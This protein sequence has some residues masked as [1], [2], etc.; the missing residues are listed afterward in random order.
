MNKLLICLIGITLIICKGKPKMQTVED[1]FFK[2]DIPWVTNIENQFEP[3][4]IPIV[5]KTN[6]EDILKFYPDGPNARKSFIRIQTKVD[7]FKTCKYD[8]KILFQQLTSEPINGEGFAGYSGKEYIYFWVYLQNGIVSCYTVKH[9]VMGKNGEWDKG[10][11]DTNAKE[12]NGKE[13]DEQN[14]IYW[15]QRSQKDRDRYFVKPT[16]FGREAWIKEGE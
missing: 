5:G 3:K 11:Y 15:S 12:L 9:L 1:P 14:Y 13:I 7:Q 4:S 8:R 16:D 6:E 10:K 2:D